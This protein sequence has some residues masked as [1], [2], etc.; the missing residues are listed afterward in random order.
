MK[1]SR[2]L[3]TFTFILY[4]TCLL[5]FTQS[6]FADEPALQISYQ[7]MLKIA[8]KIWYNESGGTISG[9]TSWSDGENFASMGIGHF[10]W[11]PPSRGAQNETFSQL[12]RFMEERGVKMPYWLRSPAPPCPWQN[13]IQFVQEQYSPM[14][15]QL[16]QFLIATIPLQA[17]FMVTRL[18]N[19]YARMLEN[20]PEYE[21]VYVRHQFY[22]VAA[23]AQ[24]I[25]VLVDYVNFKGDGAADAANHSSHQGAGLLQ[26]LEEMQHAPASNTPIEQFAW[27]ANQVLTR[28]VAQSSGED[29]KWLAGWRNRIKSYAA[30]ESQ[31]LF[32]ARNLQ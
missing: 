17:E 12:L 32:Y 27:A 15:Q 8:V 6:V 23:T 7:D 11:Y 26:V 31:Q 25:Y 5:I 10:I 3:R 9:L 24:G 14:M 19:A 30:G 28:R 20:V 2:F 21:K 29:A 18:N 13:R 16:R 22:R 4:A 1:H